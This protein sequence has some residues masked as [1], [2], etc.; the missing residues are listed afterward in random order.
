[1][2]SERN[3][4]YANKQNADALSVRSGLLGH[5]RADSISSIRATPT[6]PLASPRELPGPGKI[7]RRSSDWKDAREAYD[8]DDTSVSPTVAEHD[9]KVKS[10]TAG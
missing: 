1:M 4:Y 2:S 9:E 7:S 6:S 3:S 10:K 5:G 8:E